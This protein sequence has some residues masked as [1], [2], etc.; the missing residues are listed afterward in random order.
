M[1]GLEILNDMTNEELNVIVRIILDEGGPTEEL[2]D[3]D[4]YQKYS[5]DHHKYVNLIESE[6]I[7]FGSNTFWDN[8][9]YKE[10]VCD[11]C[12]KLNVNYNSGRTLEH[13]EHNLLEKVLEQTWEEMSESDKQ[14]VLKTVSKGN[15]PIA[16]IGATTL[17]GLFRAGGFASYQL[18]VIIAN[19]VAK[20]I[21][22][23][24]LSL[25]T[26]AGLTRALSIFTGPVGMALTA[27][28]TV[29]SF[30]GPA[31][32]VTIPATVYIAGMRS[33]YNNK[34]LANVYF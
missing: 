32:R 34:E 14:E 9:S 11:V 21:V 7:K 18:A 28:W 15:K 25:A 12:D 31:Y 8:K 30:A 16:Q 2:T 19:A 10:I 20:Q 1:N 23:H 4:S 13:I 24:G 27:L 33:I 6:I 5:P 3:Y 26:N 22:G 17:I 29:F